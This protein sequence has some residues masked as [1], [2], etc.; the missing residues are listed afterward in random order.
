MITQYE[1]RKKGYEKVAYPHSSLEPILKDT[2][3]L[4]VYQEQ[5][6]YILHMAGI[7]W[8]TVDYVR[9]IIS[10]S[11]GIEQML[12]FREMYVKGCLEKGLLSEEE[13]NKVFD[14][15]AH[16]GSYGFNK[17]H[18]V[19]YS[20]LTYY[21]A[22]LKRYYP[23]EYFCAYLMH[24]G[25]EELVLRELKRLGISVKFP[26]VNVSDVSWSMKNKE[27]VCGLSAIKGLGEK[28]SSKIVEERK[29]R[30]EYTSIEDFVRRTGVG[31]TVLE[32]LSKAGALDGLLP[33]DMDTSLFGNANPDAPRVSEKEKL[34]N[35]V[36][37]MP[38]L[39]ML[40]VFGGYRKFVE[41]LKSLWST[42]GGRITKSV[43]V[44]AS[45]LFQ[46]KLYLFGQMGTVKYGYRENIREAAIAGTADN[47]GAAY[48]YLTDD[49]GHIMVV[50][51]E[52]EVLNNQEYIAGLCG[53][54]VVVESF[55]KYHRSNV[56]STKIWK[57][58]EVSKGNISG[59][60]INF[61]QEVGTGVVNALK[62]LKCISRC[63]AVGNYVPIEVGKYR[64]MIVGEAPG[65]EENKTGRP[66][67]G[68]AGKL[69]FDALSNYGLARE[70][71]CIS[72]VMKCLPSVSG[73]ITSQNDVNKCFSSFLKREI[74]IIQPTVIL[75]L[76]GT[77]AKLL[78]KKN[79]T[80]CAGAVGWN[81]NVGCFVVYCLH[82]A[83]VLYHRENEK[84][85]LLG[86]ENF[87]RLLCKEELVKIETN[88]TDVKA[89]EQEYE[90][91]E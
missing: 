55:Q 13:A 74:E 5:V 81:E 61:F 25:E 16:F 15:I 60:P 72:N 51:P 80:S 34:S 24:R 1:K 4:P 37:V 28:I 78:G 7:P 88:E 43:E 22:W 18:C 70:M 38:F 29:R 12:K 79:I 85:F 90:Y 36:E 40:D 31:K 39:R 58:E 83:S 6:M 87:A 35:I 49:D 44:D 26:H 20:M 73:K 41:Y 67:V 75:C 82:P 2:Y 50:I 89:E 33:E 66:F 62:E 56:V 21:T 10:K 86:I 46:E 63:S 64:I 11:Q 42:V 48:A 54:V 76:G 52:E 14:I 17:S 32:L 19:A 68:R 47:L 71:F 23:K 69:L 84:M 65:N 59:L 3:G 57:M 53:K 45:N 8:K 9:K 77:F 30:G 27:I 91:E